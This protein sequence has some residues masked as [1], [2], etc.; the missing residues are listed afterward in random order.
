MIASADA[1][2]NANMKEEGGGGRTEG[3]DEGSR[4]Q[5]HVVIKRGIDGEGRVRQ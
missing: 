3:M 1:G 2:D 4:N 5:T